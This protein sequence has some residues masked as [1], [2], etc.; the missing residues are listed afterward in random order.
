MSEDDK[1]SRATLKSEPQAELPA[2]PAAAD[3][4]EQP[5]DN[6]PADDPIESEQVTYL[7]G[8][9][10]SPQTKFAGQTF[11]ANIPKTVQLPKSVFERLRGNPFFK[12]GAFD[13][14]KDA[15]KAAPITTPTTPEQYKAHAVAWFKT[16]DSLH[17][18]DE[19]WTEEEALRQQCDVGAEDLDYLSSLA[20]PRRGELK[21]KLKP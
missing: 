3:Q 4:P 2:L 13:A 14:H 10:D 20:R 5:A 19:R 7:P 9:E 1:K 6:K 17:E 18:F 12:V 11:A 16:A 15:V 21:K 8:P